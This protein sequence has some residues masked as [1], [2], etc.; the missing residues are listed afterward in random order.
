MPLALTR[1][2]RRRAYTEP[3]T[4]TIHRLI[5]QPEGIPDVSAERLLE[6]ARALSGMGP[7][8]ASSIEVVGIEGS[9]PLIA[10]AAERIAASF[11]LVA[12]VKIAPLLTVRFARTRPRQSTTPAR[13]W[14]AIRHRG[15]SRTCS[16]G[17]VTHDLSRNCP[18]A[19][20]RIV[21]L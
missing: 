17:S 3:V 18:G 16:S 1:H 19:D 12:T 9:A 13:S 15:D 10:P 14:S 8:L 6:A 7:A 11:G 20:L 2:W 21:P 4:A 5:P